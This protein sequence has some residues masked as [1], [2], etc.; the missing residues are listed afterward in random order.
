MQEKITTCLAVSVNLCNSVVKSQILIKFFSTDF[1][2]I[3]EIPFTSQVCCNWINLDEPRPLLDANIG[4]L[5]P[6][7]FRVIAVSISLYQ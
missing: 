7:S 3:L 1:I 2:V 4:A 6:Q 5:F